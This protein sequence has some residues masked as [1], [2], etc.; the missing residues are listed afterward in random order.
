MRNRE[1]VA[2]LR[3][4]YPTVPGSPAQDR[5]VLIPKPVSTLSWS[6]S[7]SVPRSLEIPVETMQSYNAS[8]V[9][10]RRHVKRLRWTPW[11]SLAPS[12]GQPSS[13]PELLLP[14]TVGLRGPLACCAGSRLFLRGAQNPGARSPVRILS[15]PLPE[16][17]V[18]PSI[19]SPSPR[20]R[21]HPLWVPIFPPNLL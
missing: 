14:W 19:T 18:H 5:H 1:D 9:R 7:L 8:V 12:L 3:S 17:S 21:G 2:S 16:H 20:P 10:T 13:F 6:S 4:L 11:G 15:L